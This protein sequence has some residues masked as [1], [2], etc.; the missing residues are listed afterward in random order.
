MY[1]TLPPGPAPSTSPT[2]DTSQHEEAPLHVRSSANFAEAADARQGAKA[3]SQ[4]LEAGPAQ[5]TVD[6]PEHVPDKAQVNKHDGASHLQDIVQES[7]KP[8]DPAPSGPASQVPPSPNVRLLLMDLFK[9]TLQHGLLPKVT[10]E[11][12]ALGRNHGAPCWKVTISL[13]ELGISA[14]GHASNRTWAEI[15][16]AI[17][18]ELK[19]S[20]P[21]ALAELQNFP[22]TK[23]SQE[24]AS[25][26]I[27]AHCQLMSVS[28]DIKK[29]VTR[30]KFDAYESRLYVGSKQLGEPAVS[31]VEDSAK[32]INTLSVAH[33]VINGHP[34]VWP[35]SLQDHFQA[36]IVFDDARLKALQAFVKGAGRY[37]TGP[38]ELFSKEN[39]GGSY[40][41][42]RGHAGSGGHLIP[43]L[44]SFL[45]GMPYPSSM[46]EMLILGAS[47]RCLEPAIVLAALGRHEIYQRLRHAPESHGKYFRLDPTLRKTMFGDHPSLVLLFQRLRKYKPDSA[48]KDGWTAAELLGNYDPS[49]IHSLN[50]A[51][52]DIERKLATAGLVRNSGQDSDIQIPGSE[53][54]VGARPFGGGLNSNSTQMDIVHHLLAIGFGHNIAKYGYGTLVP[55]A[56]PELRV[57]SRIV[58][59]ESLSKVPMRAKQL[60]RTLQNGPLAVLSGTVEHPEGHDLAARYST[61]ISTW[62]AVLFGKDLSL[63]EETEVPPVPGAA[64]VVLNGWLP[65]LIKS[66][67]HRVSDKQ[68]RALVIEARDMLHRAMNM[69]MLD[70]IQY[71][72]TSIE[73]YR[74]LKKV[75]N[76][77]VVDAK[78][79][80]WAA[81]EVDTAKGEKNDTIKGKTRKKK[82]S[83]KDKRKDTVKD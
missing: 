36:K 51:A 69:A 17:E 23:I 3:G 45:A 43:D 77:V 44:K 58:H 14:S 50:A 15:A 64:Q 25:E 30:T 56:V 72:W 24:N 13:H 22:G 29:H 4:A 32:G 47:L 63:A 82:Y 52:R 61:P 5:R 66:Q 67:A 53:I 57:G 38:R 54:Q 21:E 39:S 20:S 46:T 6:Y 79:R 35:E 55:G 74:L 31:A 7:T 16:A 71:G 9:R 49:G 11:P 12:T 41:L 83:G 81:V 18:F 70:Y 48:T 73:F 10:A 37:L 75:P 42:N 1:T 27:R 78:S 60:K 76:E 40:K 28:T 80:A 19:L 34:D 8:S 65:V 62:Q 26:I 2:S 59:I 33:S 68:A